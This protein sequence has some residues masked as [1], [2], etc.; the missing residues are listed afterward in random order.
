[1]DATVTR[2]TGLLEIQV[3]HMDIEQAELIARS[4]SAVLVTEG[5]TYTS[6]GSISIQL[7]DEPLD[8]RWPVR[9]NVPTNAFTGFFLG[10]LAGVAYVYFKADRI[11][12]RHQLIHED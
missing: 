6:G 12:R 4:V 11:R 3:Y 8:S 2:G 9:P 7:V 10:G 5:W 1:V